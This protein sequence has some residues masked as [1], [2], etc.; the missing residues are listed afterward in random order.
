VT[1][2]I[3]SLQLLEE[4]KG[5]SGGTRAVICRIRGGGGVLRCG[6]GI[7]FISAYGW[8]NA[9]TRGENGRYVRFEVNQPK[10]RVI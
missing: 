5:S 6:D 9:G 8:R 10:R 1:D 4:E 2:S 3:R 7:L